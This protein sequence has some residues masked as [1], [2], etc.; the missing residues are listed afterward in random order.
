M[1]KRYRVILLS[2]SFVLL[3]VVGF[4]IEGS[5]INLL[6]SFWYTSGLVLLILMSLVDQPFFS[7]DS[8]I[9]VNAITALMALLLV[10]DDNKDG[11]YVFF[12]IYT[13]YLL[14]SSYLLMIIRNKSLKTEGKLIQFTSRF[15]RIIGKPNTIFS[16]FFLWGAMM[17]Y[18]TNS[19]QF[20]TLLLFWIIFMLMNI[21]ELS[22]VIEKLFEKSN[23][24]NEGIGKIFGVQSLNTFLVKVERNNKKIDLFDFVE[25]KY[26]VDKKIHRGFICEM[27]LLDQEQWLKVIT[28]E[29]IDKLFSEKN[30]QI[31]YLNDVVYKIEDNSF[32]NILDQF[33]G[34]VTEGTEIQKIKFIY[35]SKVVIKEG[36]LIEIKMEDKNVVYQVIEGR[37]MI[38]NLTNKNQSGYI[39]GEAVQL[40]TWNHSKSLFE[41]FG[42]VPSINTPIYLANPLPSVEIKS[43]EI[44]IGNLPKNNYP[45]ILNKEIAII[46]H[47]AIIGV[48]G[49][50]KS[51]FSRFLIREFVKG[52]DTKVICIDFTGEYKQKFI[53]INIVDIVNITD[54]QII[55]QHINI[56]E[57]EEAKFANQRDNDLIIKSKFEI[58]QIIKS[59]LDNF[60]KSNEKLAVFELPEVHNTSSVMYYTMA[61]IKTLFQIARNNK[62]GNKISLVLEE[63][64]TIIPEW[65][66]AG[67]TDKNTQAVVNSLAQIALQG[68]KYN[69]GLLVIAQRTANVS[70]T[71][72]TQCNTIIAF[73]EFDRTSID[74]LANYFG[75]DIAGSA[76]NLKFRHA[77]AAGKALK[78][79]VPMIFEVP[80]INEIIA[81]DSSQEFSNESLETHLQS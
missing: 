34:I 24:K 71:I 1:S 7:K 19:N 33:V 38:E 42:W 18:T 48:T 9:F 76:N 52:D 43:D 61:F 41:K 30:N 79:N 55:L 74:Y 72:L 23:I 13:I 75:N 29:N 27:M 70:K 25:V 44:L 26:S 50:G 28:N 57:I 17:Q 65:N 20:N 32:E 16:A 31:N 10:P 3:Q 14:I 59:A 39:I 58:H 60:L 63:A 69:I 22:R 8:N 37:A 35:N 45:V 4:I 53:D 78:S 46:H 11:I 12:I 51:V 73:Q 15:N 6:N 54:S 77:I 56:I 62:D 80:D 81:I 49:T 21:P 47:T 40:G 66:F 36:T 67:S 2:C 68:R 64:H 5:M